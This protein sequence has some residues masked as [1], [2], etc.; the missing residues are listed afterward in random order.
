MIALAQVRASGMRKQLADDEVADAH[1][2]RRGETA[3]VAVRLSV[4]GV[5]IPMGSSEY[6][7]L[8]GGIAVGTSVHSGKIASPS[9]FMFGPPRLPRDRELAGGR[10]VRF[11]EAV[12][13]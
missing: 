2:M 11:G 5:P 1:A 3:N 6:S 4:C 7:R 13:S 9:A 8:R 10:P 12:R